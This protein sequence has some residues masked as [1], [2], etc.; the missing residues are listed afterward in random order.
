MLQS[1]C[2]QSSASPDI[3]AD[4]DMEQQQ[5]MTHAC[6]ARHPADSARTVV[7]MRTANVKTSTRA[8]E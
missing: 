3:D 2:P 8:T 5:S 4:I 7:E 1:V 6:S